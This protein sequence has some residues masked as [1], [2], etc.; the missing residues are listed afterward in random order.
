MPGRLGFTLKD[1]S[2]ESASFSLATGEVTAVSLPDLLTEVGALRT[3]VEGITLGVVTNEKL[4]V[5]DT[6]LSNAAATSPL[7]QVESA[8]LVVYE[9][10]LPFFDDPVNAIPNEGFG[11][12]FTMTIPTAEIATA[13]RLQTNSDLANLAEAGMA[14]FVT[15]FEE[16]ARSPYGGTV[17]VIEI[18]HVGRNS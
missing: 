2:R 13:T 14:A 12:Q 3:A 7:A 8:W 11:R 18:R 16:T 15:A 5:F 4:S 17:N 9:D 1:Y 10:I 6:N